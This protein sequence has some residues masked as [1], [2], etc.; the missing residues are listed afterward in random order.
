[1]RYIIDTQDTEGIIGIQ[2]DRWKKENKLVL[3]EK[4]E[5]VVEIKE[6]LER[7]ARALETLKKAGY[8][9]EVMEIFIMKKTN[10]GASKVQNVL[11]MQDE[12][13]KQIGVLKK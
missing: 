6:H 3:I 12:F 9:S 10:L 11:K 8:S 7:I 4:G 5:P 2:I 1:M 13:F